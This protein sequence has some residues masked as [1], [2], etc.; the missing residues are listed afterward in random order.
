VNS[1][2]ADS[3]EGNERVLPAGQADPVTTAT[4]GPDGGVDPPIARGQMSMQSRQELSNFMSTAVLPK[5]NPVYEK[6]WEKVFVKKGTGLDDPFLTE[7]TADEKTTLV[8]L[9]M[10]RRHEAGKRGKAATYFTA[11]VRQMY[12][13][14]MLPT[15]FFESSVI[16]TARVSCDEPSELRALKDNGPVATVKLPI[17]KEILADLRMRSWP[18]GWSDE[19]KKVKSVYVGTM[20][21]RRRAES[22]NSPSVSLAVRIT[23]RG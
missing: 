9:M 14:V 10:M 11:A 21:S 23:V 3:T 4:E 22:E 18:E 12:A 1:L 17:C 8:A 20:A 7:C 13:R 2:G 5:T 16:T 6:D 19:A 15:A